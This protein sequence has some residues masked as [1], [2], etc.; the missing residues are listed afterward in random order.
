MKLKFLIKFLVSLI[1]L[2][3]VLR[4]ID[5]NFNSLKAQISNISIPA[6]VSILL[7]YAG[8]QC[9]SAFK[10][11]LIARSAKIP[12]NYP[13]ALKAYFIGT[14]VNCY[15]LG[16]LG[17]DLARGLLLAEGHKLKAEAI[18]SVLADRLHGLTI[19][20]L[21]GACGSLLSILVGKYTQHPFLIY[22]LI[23]LGFG[24]AI[25]WFIG[26]A[27]LIRIIPAQNKWHAKIASILLVFP[28]QPSRIA[29]ISA[30][31]VLFHFTQISLHWFI[32]LQLG[33]HI[34][35]EYLLVAIPIVNI[36]STLPI[37]WN[38]LGVRENSYVFFLVPAVLSSTQAVSLG[39]IWLLCVLVTSAV[40]GIIAFVTGD[41]EAVLRKNSAPA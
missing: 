2:L 29:I 22:L 4:L 1:M 11:S 13:T 27:V 19:L 14:F 24:M 5:F 33:A 18:T 28:K 32:A 31:S 17:G 16:V 26:P 34:S 8:G 36:I 37:S 35:L 40:G 39:A 15:G 12:V 7:W 10:W 30:I 9:I 41:F 3:L 25:G 38:G 23:V 6:I 20:A 21:I